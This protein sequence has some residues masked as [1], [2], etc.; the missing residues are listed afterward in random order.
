MY[1]KIRNLS[2]ANCAFLL[3][4]LPF[5]LES[6][7]LTKNNNNNNYNNN[8][9]TFLARDEQRGQE[10]VKQLSSEGLTS[11]FHPLDILSEESIEKIKKFLIDQYGG[12]DLLV[13]NAGIAYKVCSLKL[14][15]I[16]F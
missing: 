6:K 5:Q 4:T 14:L 2:S 11:I 1:G 15:N 10:A 7:I 9:V 3:I 12:L 16:E 13:N 8:N